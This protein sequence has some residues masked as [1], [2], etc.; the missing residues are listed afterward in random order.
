MQS[1]RVLFALPFAL[2]LVASLAS[3]AVAAVARTTVPV[4]GSVAGSV[5]V[6]PLAEPGS[7]RLENHGTGTMSH[8]GRI[9]T[10]WAIPAVELDLVNRVLVVSNLEWTGTITAAN[11]D[12]ILGRYTFPSERIPFQLNGDVVFDVELE[13]TGGTGRFE[14]A[15][16]RAAAAGRANIYTED[17]QIDFDGE[18]STV[19]SAH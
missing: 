10:F 5:T 14:H 7:Y 15:S 4:K 18:M 16:G 2:L 6:I 19:G 12:Q 3:S 9:E 17:F 13:I 11:G 1:T 8:L